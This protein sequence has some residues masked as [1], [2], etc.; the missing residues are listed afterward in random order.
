MKNKPHRTVDTYNARLV[1]KGY[2][3]TYEIAYQKTFAP[4]AK[5][6]IIR[7]ILSPSIHTGH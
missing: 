4:L 7:V 3:Q 5:M 2:T 6:N 1:T